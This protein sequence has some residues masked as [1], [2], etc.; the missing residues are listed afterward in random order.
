MSLAHIFLSWIR[1][2]ALYIVAVICCLALAFKLYTHAFSRSI[3][4]SLTKRRLAE[5]LRP[6]ANRPTAAT[7]ATPTATPYSEN[8]KAL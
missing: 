1:P 8:Q 2:N 4:V 7:P 6:P 3:F 5:I